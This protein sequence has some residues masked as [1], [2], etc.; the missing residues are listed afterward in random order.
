MCLFHIKR[1]L[2]REGKWEE[3]REKEGKEINEGKEERV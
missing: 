2:R 1:L 3:I